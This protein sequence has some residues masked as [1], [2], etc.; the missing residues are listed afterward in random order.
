MGASDDDE[1]ED[2]GL[3]GLGETED[4]GIEATEDLEADSETAVLVLLETGASAPD[5]PPKTTSGPGRT[6]LVNA[7]ARKA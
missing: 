6:Q 2:D 1:A 3:V 7:L 5:P 4:T